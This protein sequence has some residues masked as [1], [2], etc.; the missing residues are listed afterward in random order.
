LMQ[1][2]YARWA[3]AIERMQCQVTVSSYTASLSYLVF[4]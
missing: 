1:G 2:L 4:C 3:L